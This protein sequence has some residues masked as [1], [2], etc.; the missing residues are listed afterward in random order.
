MW[1]KQ[2]TLLVIFLS[3]NKG[4]HIMRITKQTAI[5]LTLAVLLT[6]CSGG[7]DATAPTET[8]TPTPAPAASPEPT[9]TPAPAP[10]PTPSSGFGLVPNASGGSYP[11][12]DCVRDY[13]TGLT[14]EA[15]HPANSSL[16]YVGRTYTN[17]DS[18]LKLQI[19]TPTTGTRRV[20]TNMPSPRRR[21]E[22]P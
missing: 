5:S 6:A 19:S 20:P 4:I 13:S 12:T 10:V 16:H 1:V 15:K 21:G 9:P 8:P 22:I 18:T 2:A 14:W 17:L 7:G 11:Q 3:P